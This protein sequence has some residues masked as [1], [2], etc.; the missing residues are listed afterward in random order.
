MRTWSLVTLLA[1]SAGAAARAQEPGSVL[2]ATLRMELGAGARL[3]GELLA[4]QRDTAW[5]LLQDGRAHRVALGDVARARLPVPGLTAGKV[6]RWTLIGGVVSGALLTA[7][8]SSVQDAACAGVFPGVMLTWAAFGGISAAIAGPGWRSVPVT[9]DSLR[10]RARFP[11]GVPDA[12]VL[13]LPQ[14]DR[15]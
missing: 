3:S 6:W 11:Q 7:A 1:I 13:M 14:A 12:F 5:L 15:P 4:V 8:C 10:S 2:G 9:A